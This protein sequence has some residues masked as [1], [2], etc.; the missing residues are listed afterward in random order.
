MKI[1]G[2]YGAF[3]ILAASAACAPE[4]TV[5]PQLSN[6]SSTKSI[7]TAAEQIPLLFVVDGVRY[8]KDQVPTLNSDEVAKIQVLKGHVALE[9]YGP[10]ASY[11][12]VVITT[13]Q[14]STPRSAD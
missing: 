2:L 4:R 1:V 14:A 10:E 13:R 11:G 3:A 6:R 7:V 8:P 12:V 5:A 9:E